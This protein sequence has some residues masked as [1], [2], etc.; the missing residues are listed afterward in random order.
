MVRRSGHGA[1]GGEIA[2][3]AEATTF[4]DEHHHV[5]EDPN[6]WQADSRCREAINRR[7]SGQPLA[8]PL[9]AFQWYIGRRFRRGLSLGSGLGNLE[10]AVRRIDL[11]EEI[12]GVDS[13][14][15]SLE[16]ARSRARA[17]GLTGIS[18]TAGNL[19]T[20]HL[21]RNRYDAVFFHASLHHVR[22]IERLLAEVERAMTPDA[23]LFLEEWVGPSRTEWSDAK[24][25]RMRAIYAGLPEAWRAYPTLLA[26]VVPD[27]PS[28]AVRSSA[29]LPAVRRLFHV[30]QE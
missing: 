1:P 22:W 8:W 27:D 2:P 19:N 11:C 29:I 12:E 4:W 14:E 30:E 15:V 16:I 6:S 13:S 21:P 17:E 5:N 26:P 10:R 9:V 18:Y 28:E 7:V 24:L 25:A 20:L 3:D 23:I